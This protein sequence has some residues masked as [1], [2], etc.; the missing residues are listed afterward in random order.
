MLILSSLLQ[1]SG[2]FIH[3]LEHQFGFYHRLHHFP[4]LP[5][6]IV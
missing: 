1:F 5:I 2:I 6:I 4:I 3:K